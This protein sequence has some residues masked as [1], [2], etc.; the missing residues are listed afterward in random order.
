MLE[1]LENAIAQAEAGVSKL[2][3]DAYQIEGM[4]G[5]IGRRAVNNIASIDGLNYLEVGVWSGS[6]FCAALEGNRLHAFAIDNWSEFGGPSEAFLVNLEKFRGESSVTIFEQDAFSVDLARIGRT[7]DVYFYDGGHDEDDH[8]RALTYFYPVL[9]DTFVFI[10]DDWRWEHIRAGTEAGIAQMELEKLLW[11][12]KGLGEQDAASR[13]W[14]GM[15]F[16]VLRK[17]RT[18]SR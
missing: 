17:R 13:Y 9:G 16:S 12:E 15:L 2:T 18:E 6:T 3:E 14:N 1:H 4:S 11:I 5:R 10:V 7:I 8:R